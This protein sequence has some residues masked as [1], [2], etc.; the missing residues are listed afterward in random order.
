MLGWCGPFDVMDN[1]DIETVLK[2]ATFTKKVGV[3]D[4]DAVMLADGVI[5]LAADNARLLRLLTREAEAVARYALAIPAGGPMQPRNTDDMT[6]ARA[7]VAE[8]LTA[9]DGTLIRDKVIDEMAD[10][11]MIQRHA[12]RVYEHATR[13][14]IS[15]INTL[16][17][18]VIA[19]IDDFAT[20]D[21]EEAFAEGKGS[22]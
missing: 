9:P 19:V 1:H 8:V 7:F 20:A 11:F 18:V 10:F 13:G 3:Q 15:K 21:R 16:P 5:A 17:E 2:L 12:T 14:K 22:V 6:W 4:S